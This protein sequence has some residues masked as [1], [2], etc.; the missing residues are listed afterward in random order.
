MNLSTNVVRTVIYLFIFPLLLGCVGHCLNSF[1]GQVTDSRTH[2]PLSGVRVIL[3]VDDKVYV[4]LSK[5]QSMLTDSLGKYTIEVIT[6]TCWDKVKLI[7]VKDGYVPK[8]TDKLEDN[9]SPLS[10]SLD[11]L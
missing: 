9:I 7:F 4:N 2:L 6:G 5:E 3:W 1:K 10:V 11:K 8:I